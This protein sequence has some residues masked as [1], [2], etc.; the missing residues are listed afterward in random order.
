MN[1]GLQLTFS[2]LSEANM[3][4]IAAHY[5]AAKGTFDIFLGSTFLWGDY[6]GRIP[7]PVIDTTAWRYASAPSI[8]D[9]SYD[10]FTVEVQLVSH[11]ISSGDFV[12]DAG[13]ADSSSAAYIADGLTASASP[14]RE[15]IY[16]GGNS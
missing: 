3:N 14:V 11:S 7:V 10:R 5:L 2:H 15:Y 8:T 1:Q 16:N 4:I 12:L 6:T 13:G 9:V